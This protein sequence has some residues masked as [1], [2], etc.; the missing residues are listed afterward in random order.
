MTDLTKFP[1]AIKALWSSGR[2]TQATS[3]GTI[4]Q[5]EQWKAWDQAV[6]VA[7]QKNERV[8]ILEL[9]LDLTRKR[10]TDILEG[11]LGRI[12]TVVMGTDGNIYLLTDNGN[13]SDRIVKL[14]PK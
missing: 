14:T 4:I 2:P 8:I 1:N 13:N 12:R 9:N 3:G 5:G 11:A 7:V 10:R 6:A